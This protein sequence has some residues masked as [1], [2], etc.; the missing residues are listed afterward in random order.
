MRMG[1]LR[2]VLCIGAHADDIEVGCGG[3][4]LRLLSE[5]PDIRVH[6]VVLSASETRAREA[7]AGA[8]KFL[9]E[10]GAEAVVIKSYRDSFFPYQGQEIKE[11]FHEL[12][13]DVSPD[14]IF[15]H[16]REDRH[17]D[18]RLVSE[19]TGCAF[20][21]H[22]IL[23]YEVPKYDGDLGQPNVFVPLS[24][25]ICSRKVQSIVDVFRTQHEKPWFS[26]DTFLATLRIRGV[27]CNSKSRYAEGFHC[28]KMA[29]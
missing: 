24:E 3:T 23:E 26:E 16:R 9:G 28:R 21:D 27:E 5:R 13:R 11:Y 1:D 7:T 14:L 2:T 8:R 29:F 12:A 18:H 20:R 4:V 6:W 10:A 19:L 17:Q 22:L 25:T 15:T